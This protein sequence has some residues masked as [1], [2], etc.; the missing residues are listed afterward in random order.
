MS[1]VIKNCTECKASTKPAVTT[2]REDSSATD[3]T[4]LSE[5]APQSNTPGQH[6]AAAHQTPP[7]QMSS[8]PSYNVVPF[9]D[10]QALPGISLA[11][12]ELDNSQNAFDDLAFDNLQGFSMPIDPRI[13]DG[14]E[15]DF[16]N[17][18]SSDDPFADLPPLDDF[19]Q[20]HLPLDDLSFTTSGTFE[21]ESQR[22]TNHIP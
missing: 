9:T 22:R 4:E 20:G 10:Q 16:A 21:Q 5:S 19:Q 1:V 14:F 15:N 6:N 18:H 7:Q 2:K 3:A 12:L 17:F 11:Q 8:I 13:M